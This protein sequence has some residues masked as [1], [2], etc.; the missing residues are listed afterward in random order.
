MAKA[1]FKDREDL[2]ATIDRLGIAAVLYLVAGICCDKALH[3]EAEWQDKKLAQ[4]WDKIGAQAG[5]L[6]D[7]AEELSK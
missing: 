5:K 7:K 4:A 3:I 1:T 6:A 2:E